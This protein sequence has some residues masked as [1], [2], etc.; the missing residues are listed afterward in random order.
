MLR[1]KSWPTSSMIDQ[2]TK[3]LTSTKQNLT[4]KT[5]FNQSAKKQCLWGLIYEHKKLY[6]QM[7][8]YWNE[9]LKSFLINYILQQKLQKTNKFNNIALKWRT[10]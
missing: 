2:S 10:N 4:L 7:S 3:L 9:F 6:M 1:D 8:S 5:L